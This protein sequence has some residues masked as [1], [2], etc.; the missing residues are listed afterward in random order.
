MAMPKRHARG[1]H[2]EQTVAFLLGELG[3]AILEGPSG[4]ASGGHG[5]TAPG[6]D[7]V[8]YHPKT[9]DLVIYDNK[10]FK[11]KGNVSSVT[12]LTKNLEKNLNSLILRLHNVAEFPHRARV[13]LW[14]RRAQDSLTNGGQWPKSLRLAVTGV[15]GNATG[16][17]ERLRKLGIQFL[18]LDTLSRRPHMRAMQALARSADSIE[19]RGAQRIV[20][21]LADDGQRTATRIS[22]TALQKFLREDYPRIVSSRLVA[23]SKTKT[24][25]RAKSLVPVLGWTMSGWDVL[26]GLRDILRLKVWRG[27]TAIGCA[28]GDIALDAAHA[29]DLVSGVG[30]TAL[31][32][33]GQVATIS[34]A[35]GVEISRAKDKY[36]ELG[37]E[38]AKTGRLPSNARLKSYF[39]LDEK[40]II[41]IKAAFKVK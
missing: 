33:G 1:H 9:G 18:D 24:A 35:I 31:S 2:G 32:V 40:T 36:R 21:Q 10:A 16:V 3:Y 13:L 38:I 4:G 12:A 25:Q 11:R 23:L 39:G 34:C 17:T 22:N 15:G 20:Q 6:I 37:K 41:A 8:A 7:G 28:A 19:K 30:G 14:L 27:L 26:N 5:I 29:G